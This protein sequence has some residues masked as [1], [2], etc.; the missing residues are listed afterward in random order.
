LKVNSYSGIQEGEGV[1]RRVIEF[2]P[3]LI[4]E[5]SIWEKKNAEGGDNYPEDVPIMAYATYDFGMELMTPLDVKNNWLANGYEGLS[6][7]STPEDI[8]MKT[9]F[10][11]LFHAF[12]HIP[13]D[14]NYSHYHWALRGWLKERADVQEFD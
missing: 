10:Y 6:K 3:P 14:P 8:L 11:D 12:C 9:L 4:V 13:E 2:N 5:Y 7:D 1:G